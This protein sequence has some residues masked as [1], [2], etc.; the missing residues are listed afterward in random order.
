MPQALFILQSLFSL[1][2]IYDV[3]SKGRDRYW[4]WLVI[5]PF[6]ELF[7]FFMVKLH[8]PEMAWLK[9]AFR[10]PGSAA[11]EPGRPS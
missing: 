9:N 1:W 11:H 2:M 10:G 7:Y 6:G 3:L 5:L 4:V 8:D